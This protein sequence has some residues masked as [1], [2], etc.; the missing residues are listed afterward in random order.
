[1]KILI[2]STFPQ[3]DGWG[4]SARDYLKAFTLTSHEVQA[5]PIV[6]SQQVL[7]PEQLPSWIPPNDITFKPD[8]YFQQCLPDYYEKY[9]HIKK[10]IGFCFTESRNLSKTGWVEK[11][12]EMDE[13]W[14]ATPQEKINLEESGV[15]TPIRVIRMPM[16]FSDTEGQL[17]S[18][19][20]M[21]GGR[22]AFYFIGEWAPRKNIND[23]LLAY[24]REFKKSDEVVLVIK[25]NLGSLKGDELNTYIHQQIDF[26]QKTFRLHDY[27][28]HY[29]EV[30]IIIEPLNN[31][32]IN[33]LHNMCSCFVNSACGESTCRPLVDAAFYGK[34]IIC[35][36]GIGATDP[37][38]K[39]TTVEARREPCIVTHPPLP[40]LY[41]GWETWMKINVFDMQA[42]LRMGYEGKL[43]INAKEDIRNIYSYESIAREISN[44]L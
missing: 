18:L 22:F 15:T 19:A 12:N 31:M 24:W 2:K 27:A 42:K 20:E 35:T 37:V 34:P 38:I 39:L 28:H 7:K 17:D 43:P 32:E 8:V 44:A 1:M 21:I 13:A 10:H 9:G 3:A 23:L 26:L 11:F 41:S 29:P 25:T 4:M 5:I 40:Y 16:E 14:V 33:Q 30:L 36:A 6:L